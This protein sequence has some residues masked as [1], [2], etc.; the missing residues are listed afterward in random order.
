MLRAPQPDW[1]LLAC[2]CLSIQPE[3]EQASTLRAQLAARPSLLRKKESLRHAIE[4]A[5]DA[6]MQTM[7]MDAGNLP[8]D[9]DADPKA[10]QA[11]TWFVENLTHLVS[12]MHALALQ[13]LR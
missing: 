13:H 11:A 10:C 9:L 7:Y 6:M 5:F 12:L 8:Q 2:T 3:A 1:K 4:P